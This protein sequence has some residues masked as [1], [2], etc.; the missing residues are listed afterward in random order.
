MNIS[1][2]KLVIGSKEELLFIYFFFFKPMSVENSILQ[3]LAN[4]GPISM[5]IL[6][7]FLL[8]GHFFYV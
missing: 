5:I 2:S 7:M 4:N 3:T 6:S 1:H 8:F